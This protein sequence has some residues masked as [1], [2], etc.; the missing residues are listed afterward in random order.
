MKTRMM[1]SQYYIIMFKNLSNIWYRRA[2]PMV[3]LNWNTRFN[4]EI[5][6]LKILNIKERRA[7]IMLLWFIITVRDAVAP[8]PSSTLRHF[9]K[10]NFTFDTA[11]FWRLLCALLN[12]N[13]KMKHLKTMS[14]FCIKIVCNKIV[15]TVSFGWQSYSGQ[16]SHF[17]LS[18]HSAH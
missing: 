11:M 14:G 16:R 12:Q 10:S 1:T 4:F 3:P 2:I 6:P 18:L 15:N 8:N 17:D 13:V 5:V 9:Q 7:A